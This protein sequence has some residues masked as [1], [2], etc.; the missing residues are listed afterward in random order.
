MRD[1]QVHPSVPR[2]ARVLLVVRDRRFRAVTSTLLSQ[3]G[4]EVLDCDEGAD[5]FEV[6]VREDVD[7][8]VLEATRSL[9]AA[10]RDAARLAALPRPV[11][12]VAVSDGAQPGLAALPVLPKWGAFDDL[13]A[14]IALACAAA[15]ADGVAG[16]VN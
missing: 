4:H 15:S 13:C 3:R 12:I 16:V 7:V 11:G 9:T 8:V 5:V 6:A 14:A 1:L 10:A 2:P